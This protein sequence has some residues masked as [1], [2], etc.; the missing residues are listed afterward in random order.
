MTSENVD[1]PDRSAVGKIPDGPASSIA[2]TVDTRQRSVDEL[3]TLARD[4]HHGRVFTSRHLPDQKDIVQVFMVLAFL[5]TEQLERMADVGLI[6]EYL[7]KAGERMVNGL[8]VF[9]SCHMLTVA[10]AQ[11]VLGIIKALRDVEAQ[12][13]GAPADKLTDE[14]VAGD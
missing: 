10:D 4:I 14:Q 6:Y 9:M 5:T 13:L 11:T 7:D 12:V 3:R 1:E 8:P 2:G